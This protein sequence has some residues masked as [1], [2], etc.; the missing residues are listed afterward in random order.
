MYKELVKRG[1]KWMCCFA[2]T[3]M[4][5]FLHSHEHLNQ[6][7]N[8]CFQVKLIRILSR[9][10]RVFRRFRFKRCVQWSNLFCLQINRILY[11]YKYLAKLPIYFDIFSS[12]F[13]TFCWFAFLVLKARHDELAV[14]FVKGKEDLH[15]KLTDTR[16]KIL[17]R[18]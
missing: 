4:A 16:E 8:F 2:A 5:A 3:V 15:Y 12:V 17:K 6:F 9:K 11:K 18:T 14:K 13:M 7:I 1:W 10:S